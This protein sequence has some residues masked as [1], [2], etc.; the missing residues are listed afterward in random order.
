ML[1][2]TAIPEPKYDMQHLTCEDI[3]NIVKGPDT[4]LGSN[5]KYVE[6]L[7]SDGTIIAE[8]DMDPFIGWTTTIK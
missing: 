1:I 8:Y 3:A 2:N 6:I 4:F 7:C 5:P